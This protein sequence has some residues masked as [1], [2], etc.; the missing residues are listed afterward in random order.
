MSNRKRKLRQASLVSKI[1]VISNHFLKN[2]L[3]NQEDNDK[4]REQAMFD[5]VSFQPEK[6]LRLV[7]RNSYLAIPMSSSKYRRPANIKET[8]CV[9]AFSLSYVFILR[10]KVRIHPTRMIC[11]HSGRG[12]FR[13]RRRATARLLSVC[14]PWRGS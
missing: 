7:H 4:C 5:C 1:S 6:A 3:Q 10:Y 11:L 2:A 9:D 8:F 13:T 12:A 14:V